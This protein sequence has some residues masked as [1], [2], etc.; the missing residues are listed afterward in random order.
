MVMYINKNTDVK[1]IWEKSQVG[2]CPGVFGTADQ[3]MADNIIT[4]EV[5]RKKRNVGVHSM[6]TEKR[7][8]D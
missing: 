3:L 2:T 1:D 4:L 8:H 6:P 7:A 5:R